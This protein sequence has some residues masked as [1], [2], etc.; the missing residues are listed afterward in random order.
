MKNMSNCYEIV[1]LSE[2]TFLT[3]F[4]IINHYQWKEPGMEEKLKCANYQTG[5]FFQHGNNIKIIIYI[6]I[7]WLFQKKLTTYIEILPFIYPS[8]WTI[9]NR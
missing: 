4:N 1:E 5:Y 8:Y 2:G 7:E 6:K 3:T 9:Q